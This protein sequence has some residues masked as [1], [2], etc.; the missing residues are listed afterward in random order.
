[1]TLMMMCSFLLTGDELRALRTVF[2]RGQPPPAPP[3]P[4]VDIPPPPPPIILPVDEF[5]VPPPPTH[6]QGQDQD[7]DD[8]A[9]FAALFL[10]RNPRMCGAEGTLR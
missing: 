10:L 6:I 8:A 1:M 3:L 7:G 5:D 2:I 9:G 4:P